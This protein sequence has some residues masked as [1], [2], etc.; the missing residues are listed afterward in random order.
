MTK[1][2][3][4]L[5]AKRNIDDDFYRGMFIFVLE[6]I[7][8][9][10]RPE[11]D[12][13]PL[14]LNSPAKFYGW[15]L[16]KWLEMDWSRDCVT[17]ILS[18]IDSIFGFNGNVYQFLSTNG[19]GT[20]KETGTFI[21]WAVEMGLKPE[22]VPPSL[23]GYRHEASDRTFW[24]TGCTSVDTPRLVKRFKIEKFRKN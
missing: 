10:Y 16:D 12:D 17:A 19:Y 15:L 8:Y 6:Y 22:D 23:R 7:F 5:W 20:E 18:T 24:N 21:Q 4:I 1:E 11:D 14:S 9:F 13:E 2:E 3:T